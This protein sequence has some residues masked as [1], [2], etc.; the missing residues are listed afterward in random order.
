MYL[1]SIRNINLFTLRLLYD[2]DNLR[3][4][5]FLFVGAGSEDR[6][7]PAPGESADIGF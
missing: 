5:E 7:R 1:R 3:I 4:L 6:I 2:N